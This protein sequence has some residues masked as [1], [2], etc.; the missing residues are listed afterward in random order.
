MLRVLRG[1]S[2]ALL[3]AAGGVSVLGDWALFVAL[4]FFVYTLTG[5]ALA[6]GIVFVAQTLSRAVVGSV[7][8]VFVD[9]WDRRRTMV[10]ADLS[11][12][13]LLLALLPVHDGGRV[14]IV[15]VVAGLQ[16]AIGQFFQ[17]AKDA[18][19]PR[20]VSREDLVPANALTAL[21]DNLARIVG[22]AFGGILLDRL[23]LSSVVLIDSL[24]FLISGLL[25]ARIAV[26]AVARAIEAGGTLGGAWGRVWGEWRAG[27]SV[28]RG[29]GVLTALLI[30]LAG[31]MLAEGIIQVL[32]APFVGQVLHGDAAVLGWLMT[33]LG[34]GGLLGSL[35]V[36]RSGGVLPPLRLIPAAALTGGLVRLGMV[37]LGRLGPVLALG[38]LAG[39][40]SVLMYV[41]IP[42][43]I[44][45]R[46]EDAYRG[47]V[48]GASATTQALAML[49]GVA[50]SSALGDRVG[51]LPVMNLGCLIY[52]LAGVLALA[53]LWR[54][55]EAPA[56]ATQAGV[57]G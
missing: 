30:L 15:Y 20:L 5:S 22:P 10:A 31:V 42:A 47:R 26:P 11:R 57:N 3:W 32:L 39:F 27:L 33:A 6:T 46:V 8:G 4:P 19:V 44:Q 18:L 56:P 12:A 36:S 48:F 41:N 24:S 37:D 38:G 23:G 34:A 45:R 25:L 52:T 40:I 43:V 1:R 7:A 50:V 17:P 14:W 16:S 53:L 55:A 21:S 49:A 54:A 9:R 29:D 2:F 35:V 51:V 28:V 13:A